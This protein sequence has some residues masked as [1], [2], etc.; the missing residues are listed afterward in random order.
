MSAQV[1]TFPQGID[2]FLLWRKKYVLLACALAG[3]VVGVG[4]LL[5]SPTMYQAEARVLVEP[6][7][8]ATGVESD[9]RVNLEFLPTQ[10]ETVRSPLTVSRALKSVTITPPPGTDMEKF[11][12]VLF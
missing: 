5:W 3:V 10:A 6:R 4:Y 8:L 2:L 11:D 1:G 9:G 12:P 7:G